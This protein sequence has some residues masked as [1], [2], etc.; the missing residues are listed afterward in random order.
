[1]E[2]LIED[3]STRSSFCGT[4]FPILFLGWD[5]S[6]VLAYIDGFSLIESFFVVE[7]ELL[8]LGLVHNCVDYVFK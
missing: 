2:N 6:L 4:E 3:S 5:L 1:M 8:F 7:V